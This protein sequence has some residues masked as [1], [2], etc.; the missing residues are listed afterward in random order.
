MGLRKYFSM[1]V[2]NKRGMSIAILKKRKLLSLELSQRMKHTVQYGPFTGMKFS[3]DN[4][5]GGS[6]RGA[7]LL[8]IYEQEVLNSI[9]TT[10]KKYNVFVD[11]GAADGYYSI[12]SLISRKFK[13][14]YSFE[15]S[16]KGRD[17]IK[18]NAILNKLEN[19]LHIFGEATHN[20]YSLI[21][22]KD[23]DK[24]V[25]VIDIE[26]AEFSLLNKKSFSCL[27]KSIIFIEV[28]D[29]FFK[30]GKRKMTKLISDAKP[31]F[32]VSTLTTTS[33]DLSKFPELAH[34]GDSERWLIASEGRSKLMTWLRFDPR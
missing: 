30:D 18:K 15:M 4:W 10:P 12:G 11:L 2:M 26:G 33:R 28:H 17:V 14:S 6:D 5:W 3:H 13:T 29:W 21:P 16:A 31:F 22:K 20:F 23:L 19:K 9:M 34:Y 1:L 7:M 27:K 8:G 25:I 32:K 24:A